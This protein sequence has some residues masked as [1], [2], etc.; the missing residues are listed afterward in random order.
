MAS[1]PYSCMKNRSIL[2]F[3]CIVFILSIGMATAQDC[4][5]IGTWQR[6]DGPDIYVLYEDGTGQAPFGDQTMNCTWEHQNGVFR[7]NWTNGPGVYFIDTVTITDDCNLLNGTNSV[8]PSFN[9]VRVNHPPIA[10]NDVYT[11]DQDSV[12]RIGKPGV[13]INDTDPDRNNLTAVV[14]SLPLNG[15]LLFN[16]NGSFTYTPLPEWFGNVTFAYK[17]NDGFADSTIA[18]VWITVNKSAK[19]T[20]Y[21]I[22]TTIRGGGAVSPRGNVLVLSG[23]NQSIGIKADNMS[24][25]SMVTIDNVTIGGDD[26]IGLQNLVVTFRN[27]IANH[28][29]SAEF[30]APPHIP[31]S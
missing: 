18:Q 23:G 12:L 14:V 4:S 20:E 5:I 3:G 13:L 30:I 16:E 15:D 7:L 29:I 11:M 19:P 28:T 10:L 31:G 9:A 21:F 2:I 22:N 8:G 27:V 26:F 25:L 17:T 6:T 24:W 1:K